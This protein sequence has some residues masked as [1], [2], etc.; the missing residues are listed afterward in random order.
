MK[1]KKTITKID[2]SSNK[3]ELLI[4]IV[5]K[6]YANHYAYIAQNY[7]ANYQIKMLAKGSASTELL[8]YLGLNSTDKIVL[9]CPIKTTNRDTILSEFEKSFK[10]IKN[11]KG[12]A[13]VVPLSSIIGKLAYGFLSNNDTIIKENLTNGI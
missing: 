13:F 2:T 1:L 12:I 4:A 9:M 3:L 7:E 11:G 6:K 10:T 5:G 8:N